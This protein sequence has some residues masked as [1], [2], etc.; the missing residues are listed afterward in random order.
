MY[1]CLVVMMTAISLGSS[2]VEA[3]W[4]AS[5][6]REQ[7][8]R[9]G[10]QNFRA[11]REEAIAVSFGLKL[12]HPPTPCAP[13]RQMGKSPSFMFRFSV[14]CWSPAPSPAPLTPARGYYH[15]RNAT[16]ATR[17]RLPQPGKMIIPQRTRLS[18]PTNAQNLQNVKARHQTL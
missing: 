7:V 6:M 9:F 13:P 12:P 1:F 10:T 8:I 2:C 3:S 15:N 5:R 14:K 11:V 17:T 16:I 4:L 18:Q